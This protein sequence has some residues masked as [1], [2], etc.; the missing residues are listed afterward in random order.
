MYPT[1]LETNKKTKEKGITG[2][3]TSKLKR[4]G[5][6]DVDVSAA[7]DERILMIIL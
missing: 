4:A 5:K 2:K 6:K 3:S 1:K 7:L